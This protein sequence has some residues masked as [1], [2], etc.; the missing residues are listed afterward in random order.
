MNLLQ[1]FKTPRSYICQFYVLLEYCAEDKKSI[2]DFTTDS[3]T[4]LN[5]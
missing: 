3:D 4:K 5:S 2:T 1:T